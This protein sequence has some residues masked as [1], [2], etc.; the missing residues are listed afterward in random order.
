MAEKM[1][2][3]INRYINDLRTSTNIQEVKFLTVMMQIWEKEE[4]LMMAS[5]LAFEY[6]CLCKSIREKGK[7]E[8]DLT[9]LI[10]ETI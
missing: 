10:E 4:I 7:V 1:E 3:K 5:K 2:E 6:A 8:K 9:S